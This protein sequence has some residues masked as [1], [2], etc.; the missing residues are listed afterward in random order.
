MICGSRIAAAASAA[1]IVIPLFGTMTI[2]LVLFSCRGTLFLRF[3]FA[4]PPHLSCITAAYL[5]SSFFIRSFHLTFDLIYIYRYIYFVHR[6]RIHKIAREVYRWRGKVSCTLTTHNTT[7]VLSTLCYRTL[8][9]TGKPSD[10]EI[11]AVSRASRRRRFNR[12]V[13]DNCLESAMRY[14]YYGIGFHRSLSFDIFLISRSS[15]NFPT[16]RSAKI[17]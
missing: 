1:V 14:T 12:F 10:G 11:G 4:P 17:K 15:T 9:T 3:R 6:I 8:L 13:H 2:F 7:T 5:S 16:N